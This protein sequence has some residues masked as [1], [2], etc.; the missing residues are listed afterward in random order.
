MAIK[1]KCIAEDCS[2]E[3]VASRLYCF[4]HRNLE[5][6]EIYRAQRDGESTDMRDVPP[7]PQSPPPE[8]DIF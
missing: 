8:R 7:L 3:A 1:V 5:R 2:K 6:K 4:E